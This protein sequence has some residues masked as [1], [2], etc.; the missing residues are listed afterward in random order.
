MSVK[1]LEALFEPRAI[2]VIGAG[3]QQEQVGHI[4]LRNLVDG[5]FAGVVYPVNPHRG[6]ISGVRAHA[7]VAE[8]PTAVDLAVIC[9]PA[10]AV[11]A[12][13]R[14][15]G[16]QGVRALVVL[17]AGFREAGAQG[18][19]LEAEL[20]SEL[21]RFPA[22][23]LLG[24]N[25]LRLIVPRRA[26]N[27][28]FG[29]V[30]PAAGQLAF[31]SQSGALAT[32]IIDWAHS[33]GI[34]FSYVVTLGN[35]LDVDVADV[36][37]YLGEDQATRGLILYVESVTN[38]RR[39]MSA[40]RAFARNRPIIVYKA[41]RFAASAQAAFSHTG[42]LA[43]ADDVYEAAFRRAGLVR[44]SRIEEVFSTAGLLAREQPAR[45]GRLAIVTNAGGP[46]VMA[47]DA[48]LARGGTLASLSEETLAKLDAALPAPW[49]HGNP[50]DV[51]GDARR[52][53]YATAVSAALADPGVDGVLAI[54]TPQAMSDPIGSASALLEAVG[55]TEIARKP[56]L[57]AWMGG[58]SV[59]RAATLLAQGGVASYAYPEQAIDAFMDLVAYARNLAILHETPRAVPAALHL[60]RSRATSVLAQEGLGEE[61]GDGALSAHVTKRLLDAY[62]IEVTESV[63]ASDARSAAAAAHRIGFPL[64]MKI[65]SPQIT[66]KSDIGGV[67]RGLSTAEQVATAYE[68]MVARV[69][70]LRPQATVRGVTLEPMVRDVLVE[71]LLGARQ[72]A[73]FGAVVLLGA[74]G[75]AAELLSDRVL[76]LP[77]LNERL[78]RAALESLRVWPLLRGYRG[79]AQAAVERLVE[80]MIRFSYLVADHPELL[81]VEINPLAVRSDDV[82]AL[83]ARALVDT[84]RLAHPP[85]PFSHLAIRPY[86]EEHTREALTRSGLHVRLRAIMPEDEPRWHEMLD[87]CSAESIFRRFR[88]PFNHTHEAASRFCFIDYDR[89]LAIVAELLEGPDAGRLAGVGRLV[90]DPDRQRAEYALL[91]ADPWQRQGLGDLITERCLEIAR[92]WGLESVYAETGAENLGMIAV[93]RSHGFTL[94][95]RAEEGLV[96]GERKL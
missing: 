45:S 79:R 78:A 10:A 57:A 81:E 86:P 2:A 73:T 23:R 66:H 16:E 26:L 39:F 14:E 31:I 71:L 21:M 60:N 65:D 3:A 85:A 56:V 58:D 29:A 88:A 35:M 76:E 41:G 49:S 72:D 63:R 8:L 28:S 42:S 62:G 18:K 13:V 17:S 22:M 36:I 74:G 32:A 4:V 80:V 75:T 33:E 19:G 82:L 43:G 53:R 84:E 89:E 7:S 64:V 46:A 38:A 44:V 61:R 70:E 37:D 6:A 47:T 68:E 11:P 92:S 1:G 95:R 87:A 25:C 93:M 30:M 83:D 15:C 94:S 9:T 67:I 77:P 24:P 50:I 55:R 59:K 54:L 27:A 52:E 40:A 48:L 90:A 96:C 69:R 12:V 20:R 34:G 91:I 5:D 51:L